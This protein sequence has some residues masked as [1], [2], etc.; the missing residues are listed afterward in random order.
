MKKPEG[1]AELVAA[2][3]FPP[4]ERR[5]RGDAAPAL[6]IDHRE[7]CTWCQDAHKLAAQRTRKSL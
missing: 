7:A 2:R 3:W 4:G 1:R 6:G 5:G